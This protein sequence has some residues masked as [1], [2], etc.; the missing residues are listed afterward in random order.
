LAAKAAVGTPNVYMLIV[1]AQ[2]PRAPIALANK[3]NRPPVINVPP[4]TT[5]KIAFNS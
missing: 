5:A 1:K 2:M 4:N 3:G